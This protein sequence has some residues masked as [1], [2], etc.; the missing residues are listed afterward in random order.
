MKTRMERWRIGGGIIILEAVVT[1]LSS[2][3]QY[4]EKGF[5]AADDNVAVRLVM[6]LLLMDGAAR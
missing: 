2:E 3:W 5:S 6:S 1:P 4:S